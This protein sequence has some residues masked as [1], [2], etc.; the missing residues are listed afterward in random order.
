MNPTIAKL[1]GAILAS[2]L[3]LGGAFGAGWHVRGLSAEAD[4]K[5][6]QNQLLAN[7]LNDINKQLQLQAQ[8]QEQLQ[9]ALAKVP[10]KETIREV[11]KQNP[12][13]CVLPAAVAD[14]LRQ[15]VEQANATRSPSR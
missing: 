10:G 2:L 3:A 13:G 6:Q 7:Q 1:L 12:S 5:E 11:V 4:A 8:G 15:H 9:K 14:Q